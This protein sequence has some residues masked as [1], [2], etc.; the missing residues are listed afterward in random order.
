MV[1]Q[2]K[3]LTSIHENVGSILGPTQWVKDPSSIAVA[4]VQAGSYSSYLT[5]AWE[6][7]YA[8]GVA[9]KNTKQNKTKKKKER[10]KEIERGLFPQR[11]VQSL[12]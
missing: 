5:L 4:I 12:E 1:Q 2:V 8:V 7:P 11:G 3:N 6:L 10:K 9:L